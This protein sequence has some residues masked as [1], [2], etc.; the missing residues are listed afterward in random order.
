MTTMSEENARW[1]DEREIVTIYVWRR[2]AEEI[3]DATTLTVDLFATIIEATRV[4]LAKEKER[5]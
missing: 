5:D 2:T 4:A 1:I 3:V